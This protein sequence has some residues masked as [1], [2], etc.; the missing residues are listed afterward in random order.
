MPLISVHLIFLRLG[1]GG[2]SSIVGIPL[3]RETYAPVIRM[4]R[5]AR[6][7][8][9][10]AARKLSLELQQ[11]QGSK[12]EFIWINL[13]RP[14]ILLFRSFICFVLSLYMSL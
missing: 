8:D 13:K 10:E 5:A 4:R 6:S 1:V 7:G 3:L 14:V 12:L 2:F 9:P 11:N